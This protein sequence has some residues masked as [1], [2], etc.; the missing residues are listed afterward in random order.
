[1]IAQSSMCLFSFLLVGTW[2]LCLLLLDPSD[3]AIPPVKI[4]LATIENCQYYL[5]FASF[6]LFEYMVSIVLLQ[7]LLPM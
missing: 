2:H 6:P 7:V 1:M 3:Q 5:H 4:R